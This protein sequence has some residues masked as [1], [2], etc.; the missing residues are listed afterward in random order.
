MCSSDLGKTTA[1]TMVEVMKRGWT[2]SYPTF[3]CNPL[4]LGRQAQEAGMKPADY[5]ESSTGRR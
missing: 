5:K 1:D 2:P 3:N 4:L